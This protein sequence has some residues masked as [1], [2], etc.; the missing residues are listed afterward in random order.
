MAD[1]VLTADVSSI[2]DAEK[3]LKRFSDASEKL[4]RSVLTTANKVQSVSS[5]WDQANRLY[6]QGVINAKALAAAQ[7]QLA[8]ELATLNGYTKA[9]G[10][11]NTQRALAEL[12][13]AQAA[14]E[15]AK[16]TQEAARASQEAAAR[17]R[18]LRMR[19]QEG[20]AAFAKARAEMRGLREAM[21]AGIIT[22]AQ[23]R[24]RVKLLREEMNR[25]GDAARNTR[26]NVNRTGV[27]FQQAGYQI[28]DF[29]VQV[30]SGTNAFVAFGQQ[31]TQ[32]AGTLTLLGGKW[33]AIGTALGIAIPLL[34]AVGAYFSRTRRDAKDAAD[35]VKTLSDY[36]K[37]LTKSLR[38]YQDQRARVQLGVDQPNEILNREIAQARSQLAAAQ[39]ELA[40]APRSYVMMADPNDP[41]KQLRVEQETQQVKAAQ[42]KIDEARARLSKATL[43]L[44][45]LQNQER[46]RG[47]EVATNERRL[48]QNGVELAQKAVQY[49]KDSIQVR[50]ARLR[51]EREAYALMVSG[52][53]LAEP[54]KLRLIREFEQAQRITHQAE[55]QLEAREKA[56]KAAQKAAEDAQKLADYEQALGD[57]LHQRIKLLEVEQKY[58]K[59]SV[60]YLEAQ[61]EINRQN[62][63]IEMQKAG[64]NNT[65]QGYL[66]LQAKRADEIQLKIAKGADEA[67]R[68]ERAARAAASAMSSLQNMSGNLD[69]QLAGVTAQ[70]QALESGAN[71]QVAGTIARELEKAKQLRDEMLSA[72]LVDA[73]I[74]DEV[75]T[76]T[77]AKI[78]VLQEKM[79]QLKGLEESKREEKKA[80]GAGVSDSAFAFVRQFFDEDSAAMQLEQ[81]E[82][83]R[84]QALEKL[85]NF[86]AKELEILRQHNINKQTIE[87]EYQNRIAD[88]ERT[89]RQQRLSETASLFG[90]LASIAATGGKKMAKAAATFE[91]IQGVINAYGAAIKALNTPGITLAGRFAAYASVLAAGLRGVAAIRQAG[92]V[93]GGGGGGGGG[94]RIATPASAAA[95]P[96]R[97]LIQGIGPNDLITGS[98]LSEIFDKLYE[99]NENRG[100]VFQIAS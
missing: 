62:L 48:V 49:G 61:Q 23:Y 73:T 52:L 74:A 100:L 83:W 18:D 60:Q 5:G 11:L 26:L 93:G 59:N 1:L 78:D 77:V 45:Q 24:E 42:L 6:Q 70:I 53:Q 54:E 98:Q 41:S 12:R 79:N 22:A 33:I 31:A 63:Q 92:G 8:R 58:G 50:E 25:T 27:M 71:S 20:Y 28:G 13:A 66:L 76:D 29:V 2:R 32:V 15:S 56:Q 30:Q 67:E 88:I 16:A 91:A 7:T 85:A 80:A 82:L 47:I 84:T 90:A 86:N 99:E 4:G 75:F 51:H 64:V 14:R 69:I 43:A 39:A 89:A 65:I 44:S 19:Y 38:E 81:A 57:R 10:A 94:G 72:G 95:S 35:K 34:T 46:D 97:V 68:L 9:N 36:Y 17:Q 87:E 55:L 21:N 96:Q 3:A 37:E 40:S